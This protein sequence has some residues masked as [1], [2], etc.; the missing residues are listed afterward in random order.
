MVEEENRLEKEYPLVSIAII[1]YNQKEYLRECIESCLAQDYPNFEIVVADD[2]STDGTQDLLREYEAKY[3]GKFVLRLAEKN[4]GITQN[5]NAAHFAC[6]GKY[7]AW[8]GGDDLMLP[9][10]IS[11]QVAFMEKNSDCTI[12]YHNLEVF[13]SDSNQIL[14]YFNESVKINGDVRT[15]IRFGTFNGACSNL[16]R[17]DKTPKDGFDSSLPVASDWLYWVETLGNGG[18]INYIDEVLGRYRRHSNN[19]TRREDFVTQNELDHLV[20]CQIIMARFPQ[21]F[22]DVMY[23]YSKR[24]LGLRH[25]VNY[26]QCLW[27][28]ICLRPTTKAIGG[29]GIYLLTFGKVKL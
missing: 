6:K 14:Y 26:L 29:L 16:V 15:S 18:T 22:S 8:M 17:A 28:S 13:D 11:K 7:I 24:L 25:K 27:K 1:T 9:R 12:C 23:V 4:Q 10:K 3:P 2:C 21:Y 19:I 20:S 5:S